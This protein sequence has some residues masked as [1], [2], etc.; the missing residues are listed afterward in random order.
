MT[1]LAIPISRETLIA[2]D[3]DRTKIAGLT[4]TELAELFTPFKLA[5][6]QSPLMA[7]QVK[8]F[9]RTVYV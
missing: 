5:T 9:W 4:N 7:L 1:K 3:K 2:L 6:P 8:G